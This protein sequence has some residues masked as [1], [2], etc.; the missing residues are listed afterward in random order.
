MDCLVN[1]SSDPRVQ[2][3]EAWLKSKVPD[4][5]SQSIFIDLKDTREE[6]IDKG[7]ANKSSA[8]FVVELAVQAYREAGLYQTRDHTRRAKILIITGYSMQRRML[9]DR[10]N[11]LS[12]A[13]CLPGDISVRTID[14]LPKPRS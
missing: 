4:T 9:Q 10:V 13:E 5:M 2:L 6:K 7:I 12:P 11:Q 14:E 8:A 3:S 1:G